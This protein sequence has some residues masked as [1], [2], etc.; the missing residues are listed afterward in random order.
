[1]GNIGGVNIAKGKIGANVFD[2]KTGVSGLVVEGVSVPA[3][4]LNY[5]TTYKLQSVKDANLLG[6]DENYD[7]TNFVNVFRHISEFFRMAGEGATL[8][9]YLVPQD[10]TLVGML[11]DGDPTLED[12]FVKNLL[13]D[14][15]GEIRQIALATTPTNAPT[16][17]DGINTDVRNA[18]NLAQDVADWA[19]GKYMPLRI[20]IEGRDYQGNPSTL[21][22]LHTLNAPNVAIVIGQDYD[23]AASLPTQDNASPANPVYLQKFADVGT[24]LGTLSKAAINQNIGDNSAF[25]LTDKVKNIW[26]TP[27]LS[28]NIKNKDQDA[29]LQQ[30]EDK[31]FIFGIS[32][33]GL[34]GIRWNNDYTCVPIVLDASG[35]I[36]EH[37]LAYGRTVDEAVR[38]LRVAYLPEVKTSK[39]V[40]P[41]TGKLPS[42]VV[43]FFD[44]VGNTVFDDMKAKSQITEGKAYTDPDSD[45]LIAKELKVS[46]VI[47]PYGTIGEITGTINLKSTI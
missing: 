5:Q 36:N 46:Y 34:E 37:T 26:V 20:L 38:N 18:I 8:Y 25:N 16:F 47:V 10:T 14:A 43:K 4:G 35:N 17:L 9:L 19:Y 41:K 24:A 23:Y 33:V 45:L 12:G 6:L 7:A 2:N 42:A 27:G 29:S 30:L 3:N 22:D 1:M 15:D 40:D 28:N 21:I 31:G 32:Y 11:T 39:P 44:N 13:R